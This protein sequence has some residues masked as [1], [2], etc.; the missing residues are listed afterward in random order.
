MAAVQHRLFIARHAE[1]ETVSGDGRLQSAGMVP[2]TERGRRQADRLGHAFAD[3]GL[4]R[5]HAS[6][7]ARA[8]DTAERLGGAGATVIT[9]ADLQEISLGRA[10]GAPAR[11][12]FA[13]APGYL[14]D[15]DVA[16][17]GG[18]TPR[19]V[20]GRVGSAIDRIL[21]EEAAEPVVAM[22]GHGCVNRMLLAH[23]L[24]IDLRRALRLRQDWSGVNVL[25]HRSGQWELGA[26]NW[27][28]EGLAEFAR[29]RGVAGVAPEVWER[30]G[31]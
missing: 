29:T 31:R 4:R 1:T 5:V 18:E 16:L 25:E 23:L 26:L 13:S 30:L 2:L 11:E 17:G 24:G 20:L 9:H 12:A 6:T 15:P 8:I 27:N 28:P 7:Q 10:E 3:A 21:R 22:V 14:I 19:Q